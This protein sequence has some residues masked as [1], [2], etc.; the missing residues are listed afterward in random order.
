[1]SMEPIRQRHPWEHTGVLVAGGRLVVAGRD[2]EA[3]AREHG[4]PLYVFDVTSVAEQAC[5]LRS[6]L[7][8]AGLRP[9][10]RLA[11]KAQRAPEVLAAL[12]ALAPSGSPDAVGVDVCSPG[13]LLHALHHGFAPDEVSYTGTNLSERDLDTIVP[14]GVHV[15]IDLL[16]QLE[17]YGRRCPGRPVGLRL[18]PRA[19]VMR[20]HAESLYSGGRPTKFGIYEEDLDEA[21]DT[22][23]RYGLAIDT[24]HVH[25]ANAILDEELPAYDAALAP[26]ARMAERLLDAG[27]PLVEVNA[28]GGLGTPLLPGESALDLDALAGILAARFGHLDVAVGVEPGEFLT[29]LSG[30]LLAEVVTVEERL[31]TTF[32]GLDVGWNVMNDPYIYGRAIDAVVAARAGAPRDQLVTLAGHINEGNDLF[33]T[34]LPLSAV[35]EGDVVAVPSVGGYSPGMWT[36][37]CMRPRAGMLFF[38]DRI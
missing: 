10:V 35:Q 29:N 21:M 4:T 11:L 1:M 5:A 7:A 33:G 2:A 18:N 25:L 23:R 3:L 36:D 9:R 15:N 14:S 6:A 26:V 12:R 22:A 28:G 31:G 24:V 37:H 32:V 19:G 20:G 13:E 16:T 38:S 8:R 27:C 17:R 34:G 30:V